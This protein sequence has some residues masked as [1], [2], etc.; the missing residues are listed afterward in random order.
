[1]EVVEV[2]EVRMVASIAEDALALLDPG[3]GVPDAVGQTPLR[4]ATQHQS[5][6]ASPSTNRTG[7]HPVLPGDAPLLAVI[8]RQV[9][10][11]QKV[12]CYLMITNGRSSTHQ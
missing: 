5:H 2:V 1:M 7:R 11:P 6:G 12:L 10:T 3:R 8:T 4:L 9:G